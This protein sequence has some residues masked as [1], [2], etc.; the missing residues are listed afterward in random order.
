MN[1]ERGGT[2]RNSKW[3][4]H[5]SNLTIRNQ[6]KAKEKLVD[7]CITNTL[8]KIRGYFGGM[9]RE[10]GTESILQTQIFP[11]VVDTLMFGEVTGSANCSFL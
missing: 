2:Q 9:L 10:I 3:S 4:I 6:D 8:V 1:S 5:Q 11:Q 7:L